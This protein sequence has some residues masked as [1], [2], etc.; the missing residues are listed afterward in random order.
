M[1]IARVEGNVVATK[2]HPSFNG[3]RLLVC[4][5]INRSGEA[6]GS[7]VVAIDPLGA[8]HH[9]MVVVSTDGMAARL[10]VKDPKSPARLIIIAIVDHLDFS[11]KS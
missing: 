5:P 3:W 6:E 8:G 9:Q 1:T 4:Q 7:P 10:A 2:K 11:E